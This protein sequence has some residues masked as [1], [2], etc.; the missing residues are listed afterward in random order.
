MKINERVFERLNQE[1]FETQEL[2][3]RKIELFYMDDYPEILDEFVAQGKFAVWSSVDGVNYRLAVEKGY[4]DTLKDL[5]GSKVNTIWT[6]FWDDCQTDSSHYTKRVVLPGAL[7]FIVALIVF[8]LTL[9]KKYPT[10]NNALTI[11]LGVAYL[12]VVIIFRKITTNKMNQHNADALEKIKK[13]LGTDKFEELLD[14]QRKYI[15]DYTQK[16]IEEA[17]RADAEFEAQQQAALE[18]PEEENE[19]ESIET[20]EVVEETADAEIVDEE[21]KQ[22]EQK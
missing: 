13:H 1:P 9:S 2:E 19:I 20:E 17:D 14:A 18:N 12:L 15:D 10:I 5:Y 3:K 7:I 22:D 8:N 11:G 6:D 21:T 4:Y 16:L